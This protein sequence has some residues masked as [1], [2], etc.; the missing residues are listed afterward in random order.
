MET[1][2]VKIEAKVDKSTP[3]VWEFWTQPKH[4]TNWNFASDDWHCPNA[5]NNL[6]KGGEFSFTMA[7]KDGK[8]SFDL[9]GTYDEVIEYEQISYSLEDGRKVDAFFTAEPH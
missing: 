9:R 8:M 6:K 3:K 7:S 4:I 1:K 5:E 2:K